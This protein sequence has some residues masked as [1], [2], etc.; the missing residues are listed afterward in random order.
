MEKDDQVIVKANFLLSCQTN[1][2]DTYL[3]QTI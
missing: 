3:L 2:I 1:F